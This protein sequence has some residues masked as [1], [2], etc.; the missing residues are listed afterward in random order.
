MVNGPLVSGATSTALTLNSVD[1][2]DAGDYRYIVSNAAGSATSSVVSLTVLA[3][4]PAQDYTLN[5]D[6]GAGALP[7]QQPTG[8]HWDT[9]N[10]WNP[11]GE[12]ASVSAPIR[13][14]SHYHVIGG[15]RLRPPATNTV[16][17]GGDFTPGIQLIIEGTGVF[18]NGP[19]ANYTNSAPSSTLMGELR[20]KHTSPGTNY[21]K[22]LVMNGGQLENGDNGLIVIQGEMDVLTNCPIYVDPT[23]NATRGYRFESWLTGNASV[24]YHDFDSSFTAGGGLNI[25][26][27]TNTYSGTWH[28]VTGAL[29]GS[30]PN[31]L[32]TNSITVESGGALET[33]YNLNTPTA[34]LVLNGQRFLHTADT[35][36]TLTI[37]NYLVPAGTYTYAQLANSFPGNFPGSWNLQTGSTVNMASG[38]V[39]VLVGPTINNITN[40]FSVSGNSL[41]I[42]GTGGLAYGKYYMLSSTN[43][44]L[45]KASWTRNG[46]Y[47]FD[48]LGAYSFSASMTNKQTFFQLQQIVP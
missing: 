39:T 23:G 34:N 13:P 25:A 10:N 29:I 11:D 1:F 14:G 22:Q 33:T 21:I 15:S 42:S 7:I 44:A 9:P 24:E 26:G 35:V 6:T 2:G 40:T 46:P 37:G 36:R 18:T 32:G 12:P 31:S 16:F 27:P 30:G 38:S 45:P 41:I 47:P 5:F 8:N 20:F 19:G 3:S 48:G 43:V 28:V 4:S 17:A